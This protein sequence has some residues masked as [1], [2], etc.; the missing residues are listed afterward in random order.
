[1]ANSDLSAWPEHD[2]APLGHGER[3]VKR[4]ACFARQGL[5]GALAGGVVRAATVEPQPGRLQH[6]SENVLNFHS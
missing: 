4:H 1:M 2:H 6:L 5:R 3:P